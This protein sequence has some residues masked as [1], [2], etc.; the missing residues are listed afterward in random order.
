MS[1]SSKGYLLIKVLISSAALWTLCKRAK[2]T[3]TRN[4]KNIKYNAK[5]KKI[6][7]KDSFPTN[8][9]LKDITSCGDGMCKLKYQT[10]SAEWKLYLKCL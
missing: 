7:I 9:E 2:E 8:Y 3:Y 4:V 10:H 5:S 1:V 6:K